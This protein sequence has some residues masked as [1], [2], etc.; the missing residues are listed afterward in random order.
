[1]NQRI[2]ELKD[3]HIKS[4]PEMQQ[5]LKNLTSAAK[6]RNL[7]K[8]LFISDGFPD[9]VKGYDWVIDE[10]LEEI[11]RLTKEYAEERAAHNSHV[12]ELLQVEK[13]RDELQKMLNDVRTEISLWNHGDYAIACIKDIVGKVKS[14]E[15]HSRTDHGAAE[16]S[17]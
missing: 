9:V 15:I 1:M 8:L 7:A 10:L 2:E 4:K 14:H 3:L 13:E 16:R 11:E 17:Q 6:S 5:F 12:T